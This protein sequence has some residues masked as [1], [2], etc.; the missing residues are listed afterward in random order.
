MAPRGAGNRDVHDRK[1]CSMNSL[2][3][4]RIHFIVP[5]YNEWQNVPFLLRNLAGFARYTGEQVSV[6]LVDDGSTDG[7]AETAEEVARRTHEL[8]VR[9][10]RHARNRGPGAA[11]RTGIATA[12]Q[13]AHDDDFIVTIEAD[14]TSDILL[15]TKML[16]RAERGSDL[17]LATVYGS[18]RIV[19]A[20]LLRSVLSAGANALVKLR[21]GLFGITTFSS[22]FRLHRASLLRRA[23]SAY[24]GRLIEEPGFVCMVELLVKLKRLGASVDEVPM[25]LDARARRGGSKMKV[26]RTVGTYLRILR[27]IARPEQFA[28]S[29]VPAPQIAPPRARMPARAPDYVTA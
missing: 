23:S 27:G 22:F 15:V 4:R 12:L 5:A 8:D 28:D 14:N 11:F 20:S 13:Q 19:G 10:I 7:T 2:R 1:R 17:V 3:R 24:G 26:L 21:F 6:V 25:L 29:A 16:D 18:G 9:I